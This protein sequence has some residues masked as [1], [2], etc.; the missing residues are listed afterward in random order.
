MLTPSETR[1]VFLALVS[2]EAEREEVARHMAMAS[3]AAVD[4][5]RREALAI[6]KEVREVMIVW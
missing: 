4:S 1:Y 3:A 5:S 6:G 2:G